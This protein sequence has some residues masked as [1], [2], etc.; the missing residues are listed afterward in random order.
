MFKLWFVA[1]LMFSLPSICFFFFFC[2][3]LLCSFYMG[4]CISVHNAAAQRRRQHAIAVGKERREALIRTKRL[5]RVAVAD[6]SEVLLE[7]DMLVDEEKAVLD[8][9]TSQTV[10]DL[11][12]AL[13]YQYVFSL[14]SS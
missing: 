10:E 14:P 11:K 13:S 4:I 2:Y 9:Q 7:G 12:S 3:N 8:S 6:D 5:C 1:V